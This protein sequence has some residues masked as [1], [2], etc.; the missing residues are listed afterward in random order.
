MA[1]LNIGTVYKSMWEGIKELPADLQAEIYNTIF[2]Y[3]FT[4]IEPEIK[5]AI[6]RAI[7]ISHKPS[8]D[9]MIARQRAQIEN[10]RK[11]G[12]PKKENP[13]E[14]QNNPTE[15]Q[16]NPTETQN[17]PTETQQNP[18]KPIE[19]QAKARVKSKDIRVKSKDIIK[20]EE[21]ENYIK[22]KEQEKIKPAETA[23]PDSPELDLAITKPKTN[24][25]TLQAQAYEYMAEKYF[26]HTGIKY[27]SKK[28]D[29]INL[30]DLIK[31]YGI[32]QVK[33]KIDW[34]ETGCIHPGVFW[35]ANGINDFSIGTLHRQ[36][37]YILP[38]LTAEQRKQQARQKK[39]AEN[40]AKVLAELA[41]QGIKITET[42]QNSTEVDHVRV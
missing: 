39:E 27:L 36:W 38:K 1:E 15:T 12:R 17:N 29:F 3:Q 8:I 10:G 2:E 34:L 41:K 18:T 40:K 22:E 31:R 6:V 7:F 5:N 16:N 26:K 30:T 20:E 9:S 37:N 21:K 14:T 25:N 42:A 13:T 11:G 28:A 35:F 4:G 32:E 23:Q 24:R 33:Q 19:T